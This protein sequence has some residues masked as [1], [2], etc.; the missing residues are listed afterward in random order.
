MPSE[1]HGYTVERPTR[2]VAPALQAQC[3][4]S[5]GSRHLVSSQRQE[6]HWRLFTATH[7]ASDWISRWI[8]DHLSRIGE[9]IFKISHHS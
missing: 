5:F 1:L 7:M 2:G 3:L 9:Q 8:C 6:S 4:L